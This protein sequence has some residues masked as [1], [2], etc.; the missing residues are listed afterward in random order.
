MDLLK[1]LDY[2]ECVARQ[3][4]ATDTDHRDRESL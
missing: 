2:L 1:S 3:G 4:V